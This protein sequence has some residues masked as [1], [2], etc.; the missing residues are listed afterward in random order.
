[1]ADFDELKDKAQDAAKQ[2]P[3]QVGKGLQEAGQF[4][5]EH[6]GGKY[7]DQIHKGQDAAQ[8]YFTGQDSQDEQ[9]QDPQVQAGQDRQP[10]QEQADPGQS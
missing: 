10:D 8:N 7:G 4:A 5:D 1:M 9:S 2:H 3:D 6:T